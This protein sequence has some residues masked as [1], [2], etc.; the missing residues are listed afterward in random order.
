MSFATVAADTCE[1]TEH[2]WDFDSDESSERIIKIEK[3]IC[4][5]TMTVPNMVHILNAPNI[6]RHQRWPIGYGREITY[7]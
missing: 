1:E 4:T 3:K 7:W 5:K 2:E 6:F